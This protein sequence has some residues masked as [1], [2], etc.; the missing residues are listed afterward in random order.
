MAKVSKVSVGRAGQTSRPAEP[1]KPDD[2]EAFYCCRCRKKYR[3]QSANFT[4][5][6]TELY[7]HYRDALG[8]TANA[9]QRMC[10]KLDVYWNPAACKVAIRGKSPDAYMLAYLTK[11]NT[12][13]FL[14][15]TYDDTIDEE[16]AHT[17]TMVVTDI[18]EDGNETPVEV[19]P[20]VPSEV[21]NL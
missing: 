6:Q 11:M 2:R 5:A 15:R 17:P 14:G 21:R 10:M 9:I 12:V 3:R 8:S 18:D 19:E 16:C 20:L 13:Q 7:Q 4:Q 1:P